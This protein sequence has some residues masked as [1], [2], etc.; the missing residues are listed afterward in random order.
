MKFFLSY[1]LAL[2]STAPGAP[3]FQIYPHPQQ[4]K[5]RE[6][7]GT[8]AASPS[9]SGADAADPEALRL[10]KDCLGAIKGDG[11]IKRIIIGERGDT[12]PRKFW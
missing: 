1:L 10:L 8:L 7:A 9:I 12:T 11:S 3:T 2:A 6:G 5:L 4:F